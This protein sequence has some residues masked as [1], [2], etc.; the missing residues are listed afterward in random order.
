M[1]FRFDSG[2]CSVLVDSGS[3]SVLLG[4]GQCSVLLGRGSGNLVFV[5]RLPVS[6]TAA[7]IFSTTRTM[8]LTR[9]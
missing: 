2:Y 5:L 9:T 7:A 6:A 1:S 8:N 3:C 4:G